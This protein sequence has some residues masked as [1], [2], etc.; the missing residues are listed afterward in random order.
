MTGLRSPTVTLSLRAVAIGALS[1]LIVKLATETQY[2]ATVTVLIG[3]VLLTG[4]GMA[5][6]L[7]RLT[8]SF[9]RDLE[10]L[11]REGA[12]TPRWLD[13]APELAVR[14]SQAVERLR[15]ARFT[16]A[17]QI[18]QARALLDTVPA[19]LIVVRDDGGIDYMNRAALTL[20][21]DALQNLADLPGA[22]GAA[23]ERMRLLRPGA[24]EVVAFADGTQLHVS[25]SRYAAGAKEQR[26]LA[27]QRIAG[28]LDA[29]E[30]KV[31]SDMA[32]V[33]AHEIMN[34]LT[35]IASLSE[36]L[37]QLL[38]ATTG[39]DERL[40]RAAESELAAALEV[41]KRRSH[42]LMSFV[43]RYRAVA[44][45]PAPDIRPVALKGF[46]EQLERLMSATFRERRID[47]TGRVTPADIRLD[48]DPELLEQALINLLRNAV[49]AVADTASPRIAVNI[50][51][52]DGSVALEVEDNGRGLPEAGTAAVL[53][54][55]YTTKPGGGGI[56]LNIARHVALAH[57]GQL[58]VREA[59][60]GGAVF[61]LIVP[62]QALRA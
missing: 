55:F 15:D 62:Q 24:A 52:A 60:G 47:F 3:L 54:P 28:E 58:E 35:P 6:E 5:R 17:R 56:G 33:L 44:E 19:A 38:S 29:V 21:R 40:S 36:S 41:I 4:L 48:A 27:L 14:R 34:S 46:L 8:R 25:C 20:A 61:S 9:E 53:T 2:Y 1:Y 43:E 23:L 18:D 10:T 31:W 16:A 22:G 45:L 57:G 30:V 32:R 50:H 7:A 12:D 51:A 39:P 37:E 13:A 59:A 11:A 49:E 26:L 42:G